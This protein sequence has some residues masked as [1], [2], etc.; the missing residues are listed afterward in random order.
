MQGLKTINMNKEKLSNFDGL[1]KVVNL[2]NKVCSYYNQC[3][4]FPESPRVDTLQKSFSSLR[5]KEDDEN[6][7]PISVIKRLGIWESC[8][9]A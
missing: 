2:M 6:Y 9:Y 4:V 3:N 8:K 7:I 5:H 1:K